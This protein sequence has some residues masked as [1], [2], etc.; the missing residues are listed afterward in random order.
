[1]PG[2][3]ALQAGPAEGGAPPSRRASAA[4]SPW[5]DTLHAA[6]WLHE[7]WLRR[8]ARSRAAGAQP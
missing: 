6:T 1:M 5:G 2:G 4:C 8:R 3:R 7:A